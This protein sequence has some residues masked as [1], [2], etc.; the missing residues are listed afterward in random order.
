MLRR[1]AVF[2]AL[3]PHIPEVLYAGDWEAGFVL[4]QSSG[5]PRPGPVQFG[6]LHEKFLHKLW[7]VLIVHKTGELLV[8]QVAAKWRTAGPLLRH[9]TG[10]LGRLALQRAARELDGQFIRCGIM[11]GDFAPWNTRVGD[12]RLFLFDWELA[13]CDAPIQWDVFHFHVQVSTLLNR[14]NGWGIAPQASGTDRACFWLYLLHSICQALEEA[15][16]NHA[17]IQARENIL[18][19]ELNRN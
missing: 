18:R 12:G 14:K 6:S 17:A 4:F 5:L 10:E 1:L 7:D 16:C 11:H 3:T 13:A 9:E 2:P 19:H 8:K 15:D